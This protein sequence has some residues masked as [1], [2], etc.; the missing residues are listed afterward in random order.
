MDALFFFSG[1][2]SADGHWYSVLVDKEVYGTKVL[3][4][5]IA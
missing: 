1:S 4:L 2:Q 5:L 3:L